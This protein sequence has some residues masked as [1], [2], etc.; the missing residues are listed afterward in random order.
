MVWVPER[1][2]G[3]NSGVYT[4]QQARRGAHVYAFEPN[5]DCYRRLHKS[6]Q[7]NGLDSRV[8]AADYAL[9][10]T[11]AAAELIV[12]EGGTGLGSL[13]LNGR[14]TPRQYAEK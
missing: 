4:V 8:S 14:P 5:P 1:Y 11:A 7:L 10:A 2:F 13:G 9:G 6:V 3:A 12:P